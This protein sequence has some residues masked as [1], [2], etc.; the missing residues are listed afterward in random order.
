MN[1]FDR[2]GRHIA[3][4]EKSMDL[5]IKHLGVNYNQFAV[6]YTL[7][8]QPFCTQKQICDEWLL[9]KQTV[10]NICKEYKDHGWI[11]FSVSEQDKRERIM[12]LT[13]TGKAQAQPIMEAT[14][15]MQNQVFNDFGKAK[16]EQL[17]SLLTEFNRLYRQHAGI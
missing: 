15:A 11:T 4:I 2:L 1:E 13:E 3:E 5:W 6:L 10:F 14:L 7:A 8:T 12:Q 17:F 9:P 16:T